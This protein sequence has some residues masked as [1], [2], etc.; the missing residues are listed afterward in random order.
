[1]KITSISRKRINRLKNLDADFL[2]KLAELLQNGFTQKD[3]LLFL[4]RQY[5]V[6]NP[7]ETSTGIELA[8]SGNNLTEILK[9]LGYRNSVISQTEL[10]DVHGEIVSNLIETSVYLKKRRETIKNIFKAVQYPLIL[11]SIFVVML[12]ILNYTV[13]PQFNSLFLSMNVE[14]GTLIKIL[15]G[16]LNIL[17]KTALLL[18]LGATVIIISFILIFKQK[19]KYKMMSMAYKVPIIRSYFKYYISYKFAREVGY[20]IKS[21]IELKVILDIFK[22]QDLNPYLK[23]VAEKIEFGIVQGLSFSEAVEQTTYLDE[24]I[25]SFIK[26][27]ELNSNVGK[28][29][30]LYSEYTIENIILRIER[31]T[32]RIQPI[33]FS[34]LGIL[35]VCLYLVIVLP[36]FQMM[37]Q[38]N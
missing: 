22:K 34:V 27:G 30:L 17:P 21:G 36:V 37:S 12:M 11:L 26:H 8:K 16:V 5:D 19:N 9:Y 24:K 10:A 3:A 2:L 20:L 18:L 14:K 6:L 15:M 29:L 25:H 31:T 35:I 32:S 13:I 38:L 7:N 1:M 4:F 23:I 33:I 28:E